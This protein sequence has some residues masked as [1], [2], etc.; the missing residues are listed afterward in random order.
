MNKEG[1]RYIAV[2]GPDLS[3]PFWKSQGI[4]NNILLRDVFVKEEKRQ[5]VAEDVQKLSSLF[6][7]HELPFPNNPY[8]RVRFLKASSYNLAIKRFGRSDELI[9]SMGFEAGEAGF[10]FVDVWSVDDE[11]EE[12]GWSREILLRKIFVHEFSH[13]LE[14]TE[15]WAQTNGKNK[16]TYAHF[17]QKGLATQP[18]AI[19]GDVSRNITEGGMRLN[20]GLARYLEHKIVNFD[21][22]P[23]DTSYAAEKEVMEYLVEKIGLEPLLKAAYLENG[24]EALDEKMRKAFGKNSLNEMLELMGSEFNENNYRNRVNE[25]EKDLKSYWKTLDYLD[26]MNLFR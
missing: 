16:N 19:F 22:D 10:G 8:S 2:P 3:V 6:A 13:C 24:L 9:G 14:Y 4:K 1:S 12:N 26:L 11:H 18:E 15:Y 20:E 5:L 23:E 21:L 25:T 17:K 7:Q